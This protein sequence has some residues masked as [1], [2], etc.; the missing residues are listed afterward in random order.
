M[1]RGAVAKVLGK[2]IAT[3]RRLEGVELFPRRDARGIYGFDPSE[4]VALAER[5]ERSEVTSARGAWL[6]RDRA[7]VHTFGRSSGN[8]C[9]ESRTRSGEREALRK[10]NAELRRALHRLCSAIE[11]E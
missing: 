5:F 1:T 6:D 11:R 3:V 8:R 10:E 2:S 4:V 7:R 9:H